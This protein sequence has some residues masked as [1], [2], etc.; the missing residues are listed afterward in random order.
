[1]KSKHDVTVLKIEACNFED[2]LF[3]DKSMIVNC[4]LESEYKT[5]AMIDN[6]CTDYSFIDI[7]VA[8]QVCEVLRISS[9][10]LNKA[11]EVKNYDERRNKDITHVIYSFMIIQNHTESFTSMMIT[12]L[13]QHSI[14][15][16]KS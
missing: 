14:I 10:K 15:L 13:D 12:K 5:Q 3:D 8:H 2:I 4:I 7:D 16:R 11:R 1:M 9:L 6:N